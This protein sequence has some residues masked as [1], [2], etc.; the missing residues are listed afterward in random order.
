MFKYRTATLHSVP[1]YAEQAPYTHT[2]QSIP[3]L[4]PFISV[5]MPGTLFVKWL[6]GGLMS[7]CGMREASYLDVCAPPGHGCFAARLQ[8]QSRME[9]GPD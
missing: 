2:H 3:Y 8:L 5:T 9:R 7:V 1:G 4:I 6:A